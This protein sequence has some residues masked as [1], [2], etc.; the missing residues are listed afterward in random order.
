MRRALVILI[1]LSCVF[2]SGAA[3]EK[4]TL[5][6]PVTQPNITDYSPRYLGIAA[7]P[8]WTLTVELKP[9]TATAQNITCTWGS[10]AN[11]KGLVCSHGTFGATTAPSGQASTQAWIIAINKANHSTANNSLNAQIMNMLISDGAFTGSVTGTP[12]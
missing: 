5:T 8:T 11:N 7:A 10:L 2:A 12:Q 1:L 9:N 4:L 6:T 3:Q